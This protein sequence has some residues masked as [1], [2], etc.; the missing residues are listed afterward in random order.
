MGSLAIDGFTGRLELVEH[1]GFRAFVVMAHTNA[2]YSPPGVGGVLLE[3]PCDSPGCS[4]RIDHD[5]KFNA[6]TNAQYVFHKAS[7]TWA[8]VSWRYDSGLVSGAIGDVMDLLGL[9]PA[10]QAAAGVSCAASSPPR[11]LESVSAHQIRLPH[12]GCQCRRLDPA[13]P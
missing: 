3:T 1:H 13:T 4:F 10:Q 11:P 5:Q 9:T 12:R 8:A 6:T 7:G 2:I